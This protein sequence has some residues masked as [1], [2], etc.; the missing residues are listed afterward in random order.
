MTERERRAEQRAAGCVQAAA[1][2]T[3][4]AVAARRLWGDDDPR[5]LGAAR[6]MAAA[7]DAAEVPGV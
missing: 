2:A 5:T 4:A 6:A 3:R 1:E 7:D